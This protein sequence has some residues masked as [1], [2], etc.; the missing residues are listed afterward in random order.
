MPLAAGPLQLGNQWTDCH[1]QPRFITRSVMLLGC[2]L[3]LENG[4]SSSISRFRRI[5]GVQC[6]PTACQ[7][8]FVMGTQYQTSEGTSYTAVQLDCRQ[9]RDK[10]RLSR[11]KTSRFKARRRNRCQVAQTNPENSKQTARSHPAGDSQGRHFWECRVSW[12][13]QTEGDRVA[14][15]DTRRPASATTQPRPESPGQV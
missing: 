12:G 10:S 14:T 4:T 3:Q 15:P 5:P 11:D 13:K 8:H 2:W 7:Q 6:E 9:I 1:A